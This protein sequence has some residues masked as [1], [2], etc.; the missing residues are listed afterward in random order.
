[1]TTMTDQALQE[2]IKEQVAKNMFEKY[3]QSMNF[4][5]NHRSATVMVSTGVIGNY[6]PLEENGGSNAVASQAKLRD[7][8]HELSTLRIETDDISV[9]TEHPKYQDL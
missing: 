8:D 1:M 7:S 4:P 5:E 9:E 6:N 3:I 2:Y